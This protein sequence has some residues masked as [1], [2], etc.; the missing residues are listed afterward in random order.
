M[1]SIIIYGKTTCPYCTYAKEFFRGKGLD[2]EFILVDDEAE[3]SKLSKKTGM[4]TVPQIF[5]NGKLIGGWIK[6]K[7]LAESGELDKILS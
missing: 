1:V 6:T 7:E 3:F 4:D 5:V 2:F